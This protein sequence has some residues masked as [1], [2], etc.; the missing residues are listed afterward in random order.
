[1]PDALLPPIAP[2]PTLAPALPPQ[3]S[4]RVQGSI[5][6]ALRAGANWAILN[7][8][9]CRV[10]SVEPARRAA[11]REGH[12]SASADTGVAA[13]G[14]YAEVALVVLED[15]LGVDRV[16]GCGGRGGPDEKQ[17]Q[18]EAVLWH[19]AELETPCG[20]V[21]RRET[22]SPGVRGIGQP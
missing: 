8:R 6:Q 9:S 18:R 7:S 16:G 3:S 12:L 1:M 14:V 13:G 10:F 2:A 4:P 5:S 22:P 11:S 15:E 21:R 17:E 20:C 19:D